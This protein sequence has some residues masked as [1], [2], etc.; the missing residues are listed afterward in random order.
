MLQEENSKFSNVHNCA[1]YSP[2]TYSI[3]YN[4]INNKKTT[5]PP[6]H[7]C[8]P[9]AFF[10]TKTFLPDTHDE[11]LNVRAAEIKSLTTHTRIL[12]ACVA[13]TQKP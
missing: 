4:S 2:C 11:I 12:N 13:G 7:R 3:T 6:S 1:K 9:Y 8:T 5:L 10:F